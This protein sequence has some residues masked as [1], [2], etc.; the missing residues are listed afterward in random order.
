MVTTRAFV[1]FH[2]RLTELLIKRRLAAATLLDDGIEHWDENLRQVEGFGLE[3]VELFRAEHEAGH[4][5]LKPS[6]LV[7]AD[8]AV[9]LDAWRP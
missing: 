4:L 3:I 6:D 2:T 9:V 1:E 7:F 5:N 8:P